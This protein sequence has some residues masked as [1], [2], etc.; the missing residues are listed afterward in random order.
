[1]TVELKKKIYKGKPYVQEMKK[2]KWKENHVHL[3]QIN[4]IILNIIQVKVFLKE[5]A[6]K[7]I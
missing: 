4:H 2:L 3:H 5:S 6:N 1:M 7:L